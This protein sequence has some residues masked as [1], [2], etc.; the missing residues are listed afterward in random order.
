MTLSKQRRH[1]KSFMSKFK[2]L[3][4]LPSVAEFYYD[5]LE[6]ISVCLLSTIFLSVDVFFKQQRGL[7]TLAVSDGSYLEQYSEHGYELIFRFKNEIL[8]MITEILN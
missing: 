8:V 2:F 6:S 3:C 7:K 4:F 1:L 5:N